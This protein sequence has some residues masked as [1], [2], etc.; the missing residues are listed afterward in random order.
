MAR[1]GRATAFVGV[2]VVLAVAQVVYEDVLF[3][4]GATGTS[5]GTLAPWVL[6]TVPLLLFLL[7]AGLLFGW[8]ILTDDSLR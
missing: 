5:A 2:A 6:V 8:A 3:F 4:L 7:L 1:W